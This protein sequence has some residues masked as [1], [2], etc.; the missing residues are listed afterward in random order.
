MSVTVREIKDYC[1]PFL[2]RKTSRFKHLKGVL[3][4]SKLKDLRLAK[5][6]A[7]PGEGARNFIA[8]LDSARA[9]L[10]EP[11]LD[12]LDEFGEHGYTDP[13]EAHHAR[14]LLWREVQSLFI[15]NGI[16]TDFGRP[17]SVGL[18]LSKRE[19]QGIPTYFFLG[20]SWS[21]NS[22][23]GR[24]YLPINGETPRLTVNVSSS[25]G[26]LMEV[27]DMLFCGA[28][29][30]L[31]V[32]QKSLVRIP[33]DELPAFIERFD[34]GENGAPLMLILHTISLRE[35]VRRLRAVMEDAASPQEVLLS[36]LNQ[37]IGSVVA[38][39]TAHIEERKANGSMPVSKEV[40]EILAYLMEATYA[41]PN[42]AYRN[43]LDRSFDFDAVMPALR[44][45][46]EL[47]GTVPSFLEGE[48]FLRAHA[49]DA[50]DEQ[51]LN[52]TGQVHTDLVSGQ[53]I[54][55]VQTSDFLTL[56]HMPLI[57]RIICN[58]SLR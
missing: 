30:N 26:R 54:R 39:E 31:D 56:E 13:Q 7:N 6:F 48:D 17:S 43:L 19:I 36:S 32:I 37:Q 58:P 47:K 35:D 53:A 3:S 10:R 34:L 42:V 12:M 11:I 20:E 24:F 44:M 52:L 8:A 46:V 4:V 33:R 9:P 22:F 49:L 51:F 38:H 16:H 21:V 27:L 41:N 40:R 57:E 28:T 23:S 14:L 25:G 45:D 29:D 55:D 50:L 2:A 18:I 1:D 15:E 5:A